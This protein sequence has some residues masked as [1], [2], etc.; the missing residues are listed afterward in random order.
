MENPQNGIQGNV[1]PAIGKEENNNFAEPSNENQPMVNTPANPTEPAVVEKQKK[2]RRKKTDNIARDFV[3]DICQKSY[4]SLPA[5]SSH[6]KTKHNVE[7]EKKS[8]GRPRKNV[9]MYFN[10]IFNIVIFNE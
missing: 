9:R 4:L 8:R 7:P 2:Q 1:E 10:I 3:C 5:L 6:K